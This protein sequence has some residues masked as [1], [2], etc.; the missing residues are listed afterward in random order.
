MHCSTTPWAMLV[1]TR[2]ALAAKMHRVPASSSLVRSYCRPWG[3]TSS[4][5]SH[6]CSVLL[7][8]AYHAASGV[9][10]AALRWVLGPSW[11]LRCDEPMLL[12]RWSR[13]LDLY[14]FSRLAPRRQTRC[15]DCAWHCPRRHAMCGVGLRSVRV[16][17][18]R[19]GSS[20]L[21]PGVLA[22]ASQSRVFAVLSGAFRVSELEVDPYYRASAQRLVPRASPSM[23]AW[24]FDG[25][26][27]VTSL[28]IVKPDAMQRRCLPKV[29][30]MP[31]RRVVLRVGF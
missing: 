30:G 22:S 14:P 15:V 7:Q 3:L 29:R 10:N 2:L 31:R 24:F 28:V 8:P 25:P 9:A 1:A 18:R 26:P 23:K 13:P 19:F 27:R 4:M 21:A 16:C 5:P 12:R 6:P 20:S 17:G 11:C